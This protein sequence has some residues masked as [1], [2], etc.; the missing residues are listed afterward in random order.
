[1]RV[2]VSGGGTGGHVYPVLTVLEALEERVSPGKDELG[3][4]YLGGGD[5]IEE[6]LTARAGVPFRAVSVGGLRGMSPWAVLQSS[7]KLGRGFGQSVRILSRF[8]PDVVFCTGGYVSVPV[9]VAAA[10]LSRP[11][12]IYLPD[13]EPGLA[14]K[15][16]SRLA[17]RVAVSCEESRGSLPERKVVVTGY[18]VRASFHEGDR[19]EARRRLGLPQ[20]GPMLLILGGSRGAHAINVAVSDDLE[21]LL[22]LASILHICGQDDWAWLQERREQLSTSMK[23]RYSPRAYLHEEMGDALA[24]AD[25]AVARAGAATLGEFPAAGLPAVLVP[26]PYSGRHQDPNADYLVKRHAAVKVANSALRLEL[27]PTVL[28]LLQDEKALTEMRSRMSALAVPRAADNLVDEI[29]RLAT[30]GR[31]RQAT[32]R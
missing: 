16:L 30:N 9:V 15:V 24:A 21:Q 13:I 20:E 10:W 12:L 23:G 4:L 26:Y 7:L 25:L 32:A 19:G 22:A 27:V 8:R 5:S 28:G 3:V 29:G 18:P 17:T 11:T 6:Q 1:M 2:L 31:A 14:V